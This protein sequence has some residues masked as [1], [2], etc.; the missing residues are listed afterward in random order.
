MSNLICYQFQAGFLICWNRIIWGLTQFK[1]VSDI[2]F[3]KL[4]IPSER[5]LETLTNVFIQELTSFF[6]VFN[7]KILTVQK[8]PLLTLKI[9][10]CLRFFMR[11]MRYTTKFFFILIRT[12]F[13]AEN[14]LHVTFNWNWLRNR[15]RP[16][17]SLVPVQ[18]RK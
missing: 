17:H 6:P 13:I 9:I 18:F 4:K 1:E 7:E 11:L 12:N 5:F 15:S 16:I 14:S 2:V 8:Q 3:I 10:Y